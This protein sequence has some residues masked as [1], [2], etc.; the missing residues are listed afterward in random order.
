MRL[1]GITIHTIADQYDQKRLKKIF[2]KD[3][4]YTKSEFMRIMLNNTEQSGGGKASDSLNRAKKYISDFYH[5][6]IKREETNPYP[7]NDDLLMD[8][9]YSNVQVAYKDLVD[10]LK[11]RFKNK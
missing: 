8:N 4:L 10:Q 3:T 2:D 6:L 5:S 1:S 7:K 11:K 9:Y